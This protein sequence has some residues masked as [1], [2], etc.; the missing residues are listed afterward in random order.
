VDQFTAI[1][2][3][4][5]TSILSVG[6]AAARPVVRDGALAVGHTMY[7][8]L[9]VDHRSFDGLHAGLLLDRFA[10]IL[11]APAVLGTPGAPHPRP[12]TER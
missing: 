8:S 3:Y 4:G 11:H 7:A 10:R 2:P 1:I 5:Q 9:N 12:A 6:R